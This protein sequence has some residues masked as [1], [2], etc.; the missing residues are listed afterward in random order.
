MVED[1]SRRSGTGPA[2]D[3]VPS[4]GR[5]SLLIGAGVAAG[6]VALAG[7]GLTLSGVFKPAVKDSTKT[8][9]LKISTFGGFFERSFAEHV[10]PAFTKATGIEVQSIE[11]PEGEQFLYQL[12][13]ANKNGSPPMDICCEGAV[14]VLRGRAQGL[15]RTYDAKRIPNLSQLPPRFIKDTQPVFDNVAA[16]SW[17][18]TFVVNTKDLSTPP[19][20]WTAL[21]GN[22][23]DSWGVM[24]GGTSPIFEITAKTYFG[25]IEILMTKEGID[26]VLSK[27]A[28]LKKNVKLWWQN[29]GTMQTALIND[30]VLGGTYMHDTAMIMAR[31]GT[32]VRSIFPKEG[33]VRATNYWCQPTAST[34]IEE[35]QEF[36]NFSCTPEA[37]ELIA[38]FVGS[39]PVLDRSKLNLT[40]KEFAAVSSDRPSIPVATEARFKFASYMD[41]KFMSMV[42]S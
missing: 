35:A 15:W 19:D 39:A 42:T 38:R 41:Q 21:W 6:A 28:E 7:A 8:R 9:R 14:D 32:P 36:L 34:K 22:Y 3:D 16:M 10:F 18:M 11:Q 4:P 5:R 37:Q 20:S 23:P 31:S 24:S 1:K 27:M 26:K 17:Y 30:E 13:T 2:S 33:A 29:E 25:G 12:A 40:D